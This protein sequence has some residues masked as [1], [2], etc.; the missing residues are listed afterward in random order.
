MTRSFR[1]GLM[2]V[3]MVI[4]PPLP[5][6]AKGGGPIRLMEPGGRVSTVK[7]DR[8]ASWWDYFSSS[9]CASCDSP[10][11]AAMLLATA[12]RAGPRNRGAPTYLFK[13]R[14]LD[15]SWPRAWL[16]YASTKKTPA[17]LVV[18]GGVS[19]KDKQWDSWTR[20]SRRMEQIIL[21]NRDRRA[22][23]TG[24]ALIAPHGSPQLPTWLPTLLL[25]VMGGLLVGLSRRVRAR[26]DGPS[27]SPKSGTIPSV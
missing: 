13:P 4:V 16:F 9:K 10:K 21:G 15:V 25:L 26:A 6:V 17:Y 14:F 5:T 1:L 20:V 11:E 8:A 24:A 23:A 22:K 18:R 3:A 27:T 12:S 7:G 19:D 2:V